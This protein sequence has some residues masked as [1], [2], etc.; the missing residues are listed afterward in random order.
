M[1]YI[2]YTD[3]AIGG[4]KRRSLCKRRASINFARM[5]FF[6]GPYPYAFNI[7]ETL[8]SASG[9]SACFSTYTASLPPIANFTKKLS[10]LVLNDL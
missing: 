7:G 2:C 5:R 8:G 3:A 9:T 1:N 4:R 10:A 6:Y